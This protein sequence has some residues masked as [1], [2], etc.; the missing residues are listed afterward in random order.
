M[1]SGPCEAAELTVVGRVIVPLS[2]DIGDPDSGSVVTMATLDELCGRDLVSS[3]D[4]NANA[5]VRFRDDVKVSVI[6]DEWRAQGMSVDDREVPGTIASITE[7]QQVPVLVAVLVALLG[8]AAAAHVLVLGVRRRSHDFAVLRAL[9]MRPRQAGAVVYWQAGILGLFAVVAGV[10]LGVLLGRLV[11]TA[12]AQ[13]SNVLVRID[14]VVPGLALL[15]A[16]VMVS[17]LTLSIW[18]A[19][20]AARLRPAPLLRSE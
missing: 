17:A 12:V 7:L 15:A 20:R 14:V 16:A 5:L 18:P 1:A 2:D 13:P 19:H 8:A 6:R 11:W 4:E 10:P 3:L 9:G